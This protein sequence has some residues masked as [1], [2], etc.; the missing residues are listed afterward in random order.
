[1]RRCCGAKTSAHTY[2]RPIPRSFVTSTRQGSSPN[3]D[4]SRVV[5]CS[6]ILAWKVQMVALLVVGMCVWRKRD[7][8]RSSSLSVAPSPVSRAARRVT[9]KT[10]QEIFHTNGT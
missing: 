10:C 6:T 1:M 2:T 9:K 5:E 8:Q 4:E 7:F 3:I